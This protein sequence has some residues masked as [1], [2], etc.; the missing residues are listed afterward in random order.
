MFTSVH[1]VFS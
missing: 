1:A